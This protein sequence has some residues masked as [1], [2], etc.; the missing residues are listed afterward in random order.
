MRPQAAFVRPELRS[1]LGTVLDAVSASFKAQL[2]VTVA[3]ECSDP[4][5]CEAFE[6]ASSEL[7]SDPQARLLT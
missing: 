1:D 3:A 4:D 5:M 7:R 6:F 2:S